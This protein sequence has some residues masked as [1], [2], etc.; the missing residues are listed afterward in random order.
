MKLADLTNKGLTPDS[1]INFGP[2]ALLTVAEL[3]KFNP[4]VV[5]KYTR[6]VKG[7]RLNKE[8]QQLLK[9]AL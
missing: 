1:K 9:A 6:T 8:A 5:E 4:D 3:I 2:Y 7:F